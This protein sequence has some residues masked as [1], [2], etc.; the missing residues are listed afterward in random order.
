MGHQILMD[1]HALF[2]EIGAKYDHYR[3]DVG[4]RL[5]HTRGHADGPAH[6]RR[7]H[8]RG[9][10]QI[11][12][13]GAASTNGPRPGRGNSGARPRR[14]GRR[15]SRATCAT[16]HLGRRSSDELARLAEARW[17]YLMIAPLSHESFV[18]FTEEVLPAL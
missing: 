4:Q 3:R 15:L 9:V 18:R 5:R 8:R 1:P 6:R 11:A 12:R 14:R 16:H 7:R 17:P 2:D 10:E 13:N